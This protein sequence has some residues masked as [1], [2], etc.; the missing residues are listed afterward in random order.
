MPTLHRQFLWFV[1]LFSN[2]GEP[3]GENARQ[4][5]AL[6]TV[7]RAARAP[8]EET[9][10][11]AEDT[12]E[13][14]PATIKALYATSIPDKHFNNETYGLFKAKAEFDAI[15]NTLKT[16]KA[17]DGRLV[18]KRIPETPTKKP[19]ETA[20]QR[21]YDETTNLVEQANDKIKAIKAKHKKAEEQL[22]E[23]EGG[24]SKP[25][26]LTEGDFSPRQ[27]GCNPATDNNGKQTLAQA[28][29]CICS[30]NTD[31]NN[32]CGNTV[33]DTSY[34]TGGTPADA[35]TLYANLAKQ[36]K[37]P[38]TLKA[39]IQVL[40][41]ALGA[42]QAVIGNAAFTGHTNTGTYVIGN[43]A[44]AHCNGN[45]SKT[46][47]IDYTK[48]VTNGDLADVA[49]I[50]NL[51]EATANIEEGKKLQAELYNLRMAI[52]QNENLAWKIRDTADIVAAVPRQTTPT[53]QQKITEID[54]ENHKTNTTCTTDNNCKWEE[55]KDGKGECKPKTRKENTATGTGEGAA[56]TD[57]KT[58]STG[59][60]S[61]VINK[62]PLLL[63]FLLF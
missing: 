51:Q 23:A 48:L 39:N 38:N 18:Y 33:G 35:A 30:G 10:A 5:Y 60:N 4:F 6:C 50:H 54:C 56:G 42:V 7:L 20:L 55:E 1:G 9:Q 2:L 16:T 36:C 63:A 15:K 17:T 62:A 21:L 52:K 41:A 59:S 34:G 11:K 58:N 53:Q 29:V 37:Q 22:S 26:K 47:C 13:A 43:G 44:A 19:A 14:V 27:S 3:A 24:H 45:D 61:F 12:T 40:T 32:I 57:G 49:W 28:L 8:L 25:T 31:G 46:T